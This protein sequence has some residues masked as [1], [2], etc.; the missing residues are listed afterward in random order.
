MVESGLDIRYVAKQCVVA[1]AHLYVMCYSC[2]EKEPDK[3]PQVS[4]PL[5][6]LPEARFQ[7]MHLAKVLGACSLFYLFDTNSVVNRLGSFSF[8]LTDKFWLIF[9]PRLSS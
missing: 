7:D 2:P 8:G 4:H 9:L 5:G 6:P 1:S 3:I